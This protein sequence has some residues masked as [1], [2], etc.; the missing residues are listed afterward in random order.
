MFIKT[1]ISAGIRGSVEKHDNVRD[2]LKEID[3][4]FTK[5]EKYLASTL[6]I[7]FSTLRLTGVEGVRDH[8]MCIMDI[9]AQLKNLEV[10]MSESF[11]VHYILCTLPP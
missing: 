10:T 11:L 2:L 6:I 8:I 1:H 9:A 7:K 3:E 4:Q 5:F